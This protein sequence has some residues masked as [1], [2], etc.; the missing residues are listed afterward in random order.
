MV[1]YDIATR[2][3]A[4]TLKL[5]I[6]L[7]NRQIEAITGI[8]PRALNN[9]ANRALERGFDPNGSRPIILDEHVRDAPKTGRS[10]KQG[11]KKEA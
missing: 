2:A 6:Q 1:Y 11:D 5:I 8:K 3:Q 7:D 9:L 4:L 10:S